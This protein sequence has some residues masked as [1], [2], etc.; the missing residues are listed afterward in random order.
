MK[1]SLWQS[2][3][4]SCLLTVAQAQTAPDRAPLPLVSPVQDKNFYLFSTIERG[5]EAEKAVEND[6]TLSQLTAAK[7]DAL[8]SA[9]KTCQAAVNCYAEAMKWSAADTDRAVEA[10]RSLYRSSE[11]IRK[12]VDGPLRRSGVSISY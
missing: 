5:G 4:I 11:A 10:L 9:V 8:N 12:M 7:R 3:A 2:V 1:Q 6:A